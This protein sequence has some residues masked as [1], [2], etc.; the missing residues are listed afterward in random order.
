MAVAPSEVGFGG[1][2][3]VLEASVEVLVGADVV[4]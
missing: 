4:F 2:K 1:I 3:Y